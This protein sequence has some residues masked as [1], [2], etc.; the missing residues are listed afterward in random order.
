[1][2]TH[3]NTQTYIYMSDLHFH[4]HTHTYIHTY[5]CVTENKHDGRRCAEKLGMTKGVLAVRRGNKGCYVLDCQNPTRY[6]K[7]AHKHEYAHARTCMCVCVFVRTY[8][9]IQVYW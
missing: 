4:K 3:K 2:H 7:S 8:L 9:C 6:H 5:I 1:M